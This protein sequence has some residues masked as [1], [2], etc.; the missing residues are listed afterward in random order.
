VIGQRLG[1]E[2]LRSAL[3]DTAEFPRPL[4]RLDWPEPFASRL[5]PE[6]L[7]AAAVLVP[8]RADEELQ[9][10]LTRRH[11][12]LRHHGGQV[13]L[14]GGSV[15]GA[16]AGPTAAALRE[17]EEEIGLPR[18]EVECIGWLDDYPTLSGF[19]IT[20]VV[21]LVPADFV[22]VPQSD[23]VAEVFE[24]PLARCLGS[25]A[26]ERRLWQRN[27]IEVCYLELHWRG[28]RIWGATAAILQDLAS[29]LV[30]HV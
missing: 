21:G 25:E 29:R 30:G 22:P 8:L 4:T 26:F 20:P 5:R 27:G 18:A 11:P 10:I 13:S 7:R 28:E 14:P 2:V 6:G 16:D 9:V 19:R 1:S 24:L 23:E 15:D 12:Q 17:A 3:A